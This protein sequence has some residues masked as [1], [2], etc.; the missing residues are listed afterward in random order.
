V[1]ALESEYPLRVRSLAIR[2][3]SGGAGAQP[4]GDGLI[5]E[6]EA[7]EPIAYSLIGE[8]RRIAPAGRA[9]GEDGA[10]GQNYLN[11]EPIPAKTEGRMAKGDVL[12]IETPGGGGYGAPSKAS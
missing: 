5:R 8:R 6:I 12:R 11:G 2:R 4:G 9:G 10:P 3:G 7:L 1:E